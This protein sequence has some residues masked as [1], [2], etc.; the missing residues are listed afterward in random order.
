MGKKIQ[1]GEIV[2][3]SKNLEA[4]LKKLDA[5]G[6]GMHELISSIQEKL[7]LELIKKLRFIATLRNQA[8]HEAEFDIDSDFNAFCDACEEAEQA[9]EKLIKPK[10]KKK[11]V[12]KPKKKEE[13]SPTAAG[14]NYLFLLPFIPGLNIIYFLFILI[15]SVLASTKY[16]IIL[17]LYLLSFAGATE[18]IMKNNE[19]HIT[20]AVI[21]FAGLYMYNIFI[22]AKI[23]QKLRYVP[24]LNIIIIIAKI[25][26]EIH[27]R[28]F[29]FSI[30]FILMSIASG[31]LVFV[32]EQYIAGGIV[33]TLASL[34]GIILFIAAGKQVQQKQV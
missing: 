17:M 18:G 11:T 1:I 31:I 30:I 9:L 25:K 7:E 3:R 15:L 23:F 29:F 13:T 12:R 24:I 26:N 34:G 22:P 4:M 8:I 27:W 5:E 6:R 10:V 32:R 19:E 16:M 33:F 21:I 14:F 20:I 28:L 2:E